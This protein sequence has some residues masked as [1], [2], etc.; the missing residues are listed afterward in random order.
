M[1]VTTTNFGEST[2]LVEVSNF[3]HNRKMDYMKLFTLLTFFIMAMVQ[4]TFAQNSCTI[5]GPGGSLATIE[6]CAG[7]S[8]LVYESDPSVIP[9]TFCGL[10]SPIPPELL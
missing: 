9:S 3:F 4:G 8:N 5:T 10:F 6:S 7:S 2:P 1:K